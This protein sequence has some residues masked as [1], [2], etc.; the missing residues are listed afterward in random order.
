LENKEQPHRE[1]QK[2]VVTSPQARDVT[3]TQPYVCQI[4]S[5]RHINVRALANG[6]LEEILVKEGQAVKKGDVMFKILPILHKARYDA[7][8]AEFDHAELEL[9]YPLDMH[10]KQAVSEHEVSLYKAKRARAKAKMELAQA[11]LN[12][13]EVKAPF[14]GLV[15]RLHE[16]VGSLINER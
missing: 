5:R 8:K 7:D 15:D 16:Q 3:I 6:Y 12:F 2:I 4:H 1:N 9:K 10:K 13:T 11:E 14:D